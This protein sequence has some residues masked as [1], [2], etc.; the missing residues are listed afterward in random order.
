MIRPG[1]N[2]GLV[3]PGLELDKSSEYSMI[4]A[5]TSDILTVL[6]DML[7]Q[8]AAINEAVDALER[9]WAQ[10][11]VSVLG[12]VGEEEELA[13][14]AHVAVEC[15]FAADFDLRAQVRLAASLVRLDRATLEARG[16]LPELTYPEVRLCLHE[17]KLNG[18]VEHNAY[19]IWA[20]MVADEAL[21][22]AGMTRSV[23]ASI[24]E[25]N[26]YMSASEFRTLLGSKPHAENDVDL[27]WEDPRAQYPTFR[28]QQSNLGRLTLPSKMGTSE[29]YTNP[30]MLFMIADLYL[31]NNLYA[32]G[33]AQITELWA[34]LKSEPNRFKL[35]YNA[36]GCLFNMLANENWIN[37]VLVKRMRSRPVVMQRRASDWYRRLRGANVT[38]HPSCVGYL[39]SCINLIITSNKL[40]VPEPSCSLSYNKRVVL[41]IGWSALD[42]YENRVS[43]L[44]VE[45]NNLYLLGPKPLWFGAAHVD[46]LLGWLQLGPEVDMHHSSL[47]PLDML[48]AVQGLADSTVKPVADIVASLQP[49]KLQSRIAKKQ[50][51]VPQAKDKDEAQCEGDAQCEFLWAALPLLG[52]ELL[53]LETG[54]IPPVGVADLPEPVFANPKS[55]QKIRAWTDWLASG[56]AASAALRLVF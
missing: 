49:R 1:S 25:R 22:I 7:K 34:S 53:T 19:L 52:E 36:Y 27:F 32:T 18:P 30:V 5:M 33:I 9:E 15:D 51:K 54:E 11:P 55:F 29:W 2:R 40:L 23:A 12:S 47:Q 26:G 43:L 41:F 10:R 39:P 6:P 20:L 3:T 48:A 21:P 16:Q 44:V 35:V 45:E 56:A 37:G 8:T 13:V 50:Q 46:A 28:A 17:A 4:K 42:P 14:S 24:P 38:L 31:R